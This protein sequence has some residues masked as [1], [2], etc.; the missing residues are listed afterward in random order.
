[1]IEKKRKPSIR[2]KGFIDDWEQRKLGEIADVTKL[3]GFE[4]TEHV[5]YSEQGNIIAL[6]GL[7]V[8]NGHLVLDDVKYIDGSNFSKLHRSKLYID[9]ILFTYVGTVGEV[10]I[11]RE[12]DRFFLA[13]NVSRIRIKSD[14]LPQYISHYMRNDNFYNSVIFPLIATSSQPAL[15]MENIRKFDISLPSNKEEQMKISIFFSSLDNLITLHQRKYDKLINI[16]KAMLEKMIPKNGSNRPEI[17]FKGFTED[18][19]LYKV[20]DICSISTGKSNTQDKIDDGKYPFYV[21]SPIVEHSDKY[22]YEEEAVLTVGDG[23]G[24]G[25]V[26]HYVDGKYDL[27]QRVYR[28]FDFNGVHGK[29]F[30]YY[31]SNHFYNRV[32]SMTAKTSVD[33]VRLEMI[34]DMEIKCPSMEEQ[35]KV[36]KF[37]TEIDNLI[38]L[39][40]QELEKLKNIKKACLDKMFL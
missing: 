18:W 36:A 35:N 14:D 25:K 22:L 20:K 40:Q 32:M 4:F 30:Y 6:R 31:F 8:K 34:A 37:F 39:H 28:M 10:A 27:H 16:K 3:A 17:R 1:M 23:V 15:S 24:T 12:N 2:F 13:P 5:V 19:K 33:S 38:T 21:R 26:F 7:N 29:Y 9:D 11:I